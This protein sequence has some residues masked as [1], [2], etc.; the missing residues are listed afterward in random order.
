MKHLR[1][2]FMLAVWAITSSR[3]WEWFMGTME[4]RNSE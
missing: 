2:L 4:P 1:F 3:P